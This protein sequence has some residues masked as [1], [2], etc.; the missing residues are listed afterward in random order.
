MKNLKSTFGLHIAWILKF[1]FGQH[2]ALNPLMGDMLHWKY[3]NGLN[4]VNQ[5]S[6]SQGKSWKNLWLWKVMESQKNIQS[7][8]KVRI[9]SQ[10]AFKM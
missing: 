7:H 4:S 9:F 3:K 10:F 8:G 2:V 6:H 5:G 1:T